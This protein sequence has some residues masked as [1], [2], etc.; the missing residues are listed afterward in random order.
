MAV[1]SAFVRRVRFGLKAARCGLKYPGLLKP[2][3]LTGIRHLLVNAKCKEIPYAPLPERTLTHLV[4]DDSAISLLNSAGRD[5]NVNG[6]ELIAI[7]SLIAAKRPRRLL[8]IGTF[9]G[10]TALQMALNAPDDAVVHTIDLPKGQS[11]TRLQVDQEDLKYILDVAKHQ[12][13]YMGTRVERKVIQHL[14]DST[15]YDWAQF[16]KDGPID[17]CF[18]D[19]GHSYDC[20]R[21]DTE[22]ALKITASNATLLWHDYDPISWPDVYRYL[23]ELGQELSLVQI[24]NTRLAVLF[25]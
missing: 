20:V 6:D 4:G 24:K 3:I 16:T 12:R 7:A 10:N 1:S 2:S 19:G 9:D 13:R 8:E 14:G 11:A 5:G 25:R 18:I 21:S 17:F 23:C 22:N 15:D